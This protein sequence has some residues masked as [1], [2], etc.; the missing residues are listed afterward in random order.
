MNEWVVRPERPAGLVGRKMDAT[1]GLVGGPGSH[2]LG[3]RRADG[4]PDA[5]MHGCMSGRQAGGLV[6]VPADGSAAWHR[7]ARH[8]MACHGRSMLPSTPPYPPSL[9][10]TNFGAKVLVGVPQ[11]GHQTV[12]SRSRLMTLWCSSISRSFQPGC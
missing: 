10:L 9:Q 6:G 11:P 4:W 5:W 12:M 3:A 2:P 8:G 1:G 7:M